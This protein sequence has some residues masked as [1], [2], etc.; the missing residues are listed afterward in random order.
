MREP[1]AFQILGLDP[2]KS[3]LADITRSY[4]SL[5]LK[6]HPDKVGPD[7]DHATA[8]ANAQRINEAREVAS[9]FVRFKPSATAFSSAAP[10]PPP[11]AQKVPNLREYYEIVQT[12]SRE[13]FVH[14]NRICEVDEHDSLKPESEQLVNDAN[15]TISRIIAEFKRKGHA[16]LMKAGL[17]DQEAETKMREIMEYWVDHQA[18]VNRIWGARRKAQTE[19]IDRTR[20]RLEERQRRKEDEKKKKRKEEEEQKMRSQHRLDKWFKPL[21]YIKKEETRPQTHRKNFMKPMKEDKAPL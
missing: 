7:I 3:T 5:M 11:P 20:Q 15:E 8:T 12:H 9:D 10:A 21:S 17:S 2:F 6:L 14:I 13:Y 18:F 16:S 19:R 4:R 1:E